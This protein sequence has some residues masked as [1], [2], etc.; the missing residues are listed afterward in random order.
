MIVARIL[1]GRLS[2]VGVEAP[3][4]VWC[5]LIPGLK[6]PVPEAAV[7]GLAHP[8][9]TDGSGADALAKASRPG[10]LRSA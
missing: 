9:E 3:F 4:G 6:A 2:V 8:D 5:A 10:K 7:E 1:L